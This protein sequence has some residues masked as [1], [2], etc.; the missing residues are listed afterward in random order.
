MSP[1]VRRLVTVTAVALGAL[2]APLALTGP[3][4]ATPPAGPTSI[5]AVAQTDPTLAGQLSGV[6]AG[7]LPSVLA[8]VG[9]PFQVTVSMWTGTAPATSTSA[10]TVTLAAPGPGTLSVTTATIPAGQSSVT[11][12][13]SYS[14]ASASIAVTATVTVKKTKLTAST[15][16]FPVDLNLAVLGG[17]SPSLLNGTAGADGNGCT[18]VDP[19]HPMCGIVSLPN[20]ATG[21]VALSLGVCPA[22]GQCRS[23]ALVTQFIANMSGYTNTAPAR[24]TIVCDK[25]LCGNGGVNKFTAMWSTTASGA[26]AAVPA[27][28]S[29]GVIGASQQYCTD[30]VSSTRDNAGDLRLVVLFL[31]DVRGSVK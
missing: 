22:G 17:Q 13:D 30:Y 24:M 21:N 7:S 14:A 28:P 10:T 2:L 15:V 16:S 26:L 25:S 5:T 29:K 27:C 23:G 4:S 31:K 6:P 11:V 18:T 8:A 1:R 12:S 19:A 9:T 20:G 3:A